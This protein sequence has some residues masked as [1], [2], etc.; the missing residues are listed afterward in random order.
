M[1]DEVLTDR[2]GPDRDQNLPPGT[3][4]L[5]MALFLVALGMLFAASMLAFVII[6]LLGLRGTFDPATGQWV[7]SASVP[8]QGA[9]ELPLLL[10]FS[11]LLMLVSSVTIHQAVEAV[12]REHQAGL[13]RWLMATMAVAGAFLLVQTPSLAM[14]LETHFDQ[15]GVTALFGLIFTLILIHALHVIGGLVP[16]VLVTVHARRGRYDH[17]YHGPVIY[18]AMYWHF[19]DVVWVVMFAV[20]LVAG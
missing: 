17:E 6:R 16:L 18:L 9:I 3:G 13:R 11:T 20:L 1:R 2:P 7:R 12:R 10:W 8:D 19:L 15:T 5:G 4:R 14:L